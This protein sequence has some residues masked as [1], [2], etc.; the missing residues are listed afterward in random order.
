M[1]VENEDV[2][3]K[4]IKNG[5]LRSRTTFVPL[6]KIFGSMMDNA[7]VKSAERLVSYFPN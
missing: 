5:Q 3:K 7:T 1:I 4:L 2:S 6:N